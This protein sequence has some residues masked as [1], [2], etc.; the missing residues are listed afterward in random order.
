M[1]SQVPWRLSKPDAAAGSPRFGESKLEHIL[2]GV[3]GRLELRHY[4]LPLPRATVLYGPSWE[5]LKRVQDMQNEEPFHFN[6]TYI[7][8]IPPEVELL[9]PVVV[10]VTVLHVALVAIGKMQSEARMQDC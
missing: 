4:S 7:S 3:T 6:C 9:V 2:L 1:L 8:F 5:R 10:V